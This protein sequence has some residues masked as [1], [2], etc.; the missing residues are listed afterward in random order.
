MRSTYP[1]AVVLAAGAQVV[2]GVVAAAAE[3]QVVVVHP[4][5]G[6]VHAVSAVQV[7]CSPCYNERRK[8]ATIL[9][10]HIINAE[11]R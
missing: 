7:V 5:V 8:L 10:C 2:A 3:D 9:Y 1:H 6:V 4:E 11:S